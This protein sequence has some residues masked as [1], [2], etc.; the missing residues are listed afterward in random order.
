MKIAAIL[1]GLCLAALIDLL[2]VLAIFSFGLVGAG[3]LAIFLAMGYVGAA[4]TA[5]TM[6]GLNANP[7]G[8]RDDKIFCIA[9]ATLGP[10]GFFVGLLYVYTHLLT[11]ERPLKRSARP[12]W[13]WSR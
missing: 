12:I 13:L 9:I 11:S 8:S 5:G 3:G 7:F 2:Q 4:I 10:L 6:N 1:V